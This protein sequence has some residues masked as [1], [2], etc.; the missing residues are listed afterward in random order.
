MDLEHQ[1]VITLTHL[2]G[3]LE[4]FVCMCGESAIGEPRLVKARIISHRW[5]AFPVVRE[6]MRR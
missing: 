1:H 2:G 5:N 3:G 6:R 4:Q